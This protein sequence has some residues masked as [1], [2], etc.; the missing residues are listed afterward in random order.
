MAKCRNFLAYALSPHQRMLEPAGHLV[1]HVSAQAIF[2]QMFESVEAFH[3]SSPYHWVRE[4]A[5]QIRTTLPLRLV[6]GTADLTL[7]YNQKYQ[8]VLR[9]LEIPHVYHVVNGIDHDI[10]RYYDAVGLEGLQFLA[11]HFRPTSER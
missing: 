8:Q 11:K 3:R 10:A 7:G 1:R 6:I 9:E 4:N 5:E 2:D